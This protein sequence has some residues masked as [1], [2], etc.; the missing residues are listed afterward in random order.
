MELSSLKSIEQATGW[1]LI[2]VDVTVSSLNF[3]EQQ[4]GNSGRVL[5]LTL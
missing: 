5:R 1:K 2:R 3:T 4:A